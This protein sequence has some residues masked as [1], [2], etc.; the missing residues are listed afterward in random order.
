M[1]KVKENDEER[2]EAWGC[3]QFTAEA[4]HGYETLE[5]MVQITIFMREERFN[6]IVHCL[7]RDV[8]DCINVWVS[9]VQGLYGA[10][11][12]GFPDYDPN[13]IKILPDKLLEEIE[14]PQ[15]AN[16]KITAL[17][18]VRNFSISLMGQ[19]KIDLSRG[20][21][22]DLLNDSSDSFDDDDTE[23]G[24]DEEE[25]NYLQIVSQQLKDNQRLMQSHGQLLCKISGILVALLVFLLVVIII[26]IM[27]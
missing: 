18:E 9:G 22:V 16:I 25:P 11:E 12:P 5:D 7:E 21:F 10:W 27:S 24:A 8:L 20:D 17:G 15:D 2:C 6:R 1:R 13:E 4:R 3:P 26:L 14:K 19:K 23:L